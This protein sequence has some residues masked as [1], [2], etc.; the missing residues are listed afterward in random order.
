[1]LC[2]HL[3]IHYPLLSGAICVCLLWHSYNQD[4]PGILPFKKLTVHSSC[5]DEKLQQSVLHSAVIK[6]AQYSIKHHH[7]RLQREN[8][9]CLVSSLSFN[10]LHWN[11]LSAYRAPHKEFRQVAQQTN[12]Y[13]FAFLQ[14]VYFS[15]KAHQQ[16]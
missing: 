9:V 14:M 11:M 7:V 2:N 10:G 13:N 4:L 6:Q 3:H 16:T 15:H 1:M 5:K 12:L 8:L